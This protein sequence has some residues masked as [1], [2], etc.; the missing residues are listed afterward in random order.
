MTA[1]KL[2]FASGRRDIGPLGTASRVLV[3]L[4]AIAVPIALAG[5]SWLELALALLALPLLATAVAALIGAAYGGLAADSLER[6]GGTCSGAACWLIAVVVVAVAGLSAVAPISGGLVFSVWLGASMLLAA[7][8]GYGGCE[9]LAAHNLI[10]GRRDQVGCVLFTPVD[11]AEARRRR[12]RAAGA[13][14]A[15]S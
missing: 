8:R 12:S 4:V 6:C 15:G 10:T 13:V 14:G 11:R 9:V 2:L 3:G 7:A 1:F 5:I